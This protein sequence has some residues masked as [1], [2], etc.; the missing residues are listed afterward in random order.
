VSLETMLE[1]ARKLALE[2]DEQIR[3]RPDAK[4]EDV[5]RLQHAISFPDLRE[6]DLLCIAALE[7]HAPQYPALADL[8]ARWYV[9]DETGTGGPDEL[10]IDLERKRTILTQAVNLAG[11]AEPDRGQ[12]DQED[13]D[14]RKP[15]TLIGRI[16]FVPRWLGRV[17]DIGG[18]IAII[19][20]VLHW[21]L[22]LL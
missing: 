22:G 8:A 13:E 15:L 20:A 9:H 6:L 14:V 5:A 16:S 12:T 21:A 2:Y 10:R 4:P 18:G 17:A 19:V 3:N 1:R 11:Q 7:R